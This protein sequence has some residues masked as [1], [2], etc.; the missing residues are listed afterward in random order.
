MFWRLALHVFLAKQSALPGYNVLLFT[1]TQRGFL[2]VSV[3]KAEM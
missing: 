1:Q 3:V 2:T